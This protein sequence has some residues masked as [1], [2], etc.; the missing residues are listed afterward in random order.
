MTR[1]TRPPL[2]DEQLAARTNPEGEYPSEADDVPEDFEYGYPDEDEEPPP[3]PV[4]QVGVPPRDLPII[5]WS[6][7]NM[8]IGDDS[9][10]VLGEARHRMSAS[11]VNHSETVDVF[12][13]PDYNVEANGTFGK[14]A[15]GASIDFTHNSSVWARVASGSTA[16][17]SVY[18]EYLID[19][20]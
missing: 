16:E 5:R 14:V 2:T 7:D 18:T 15:A 6:S 9:I 17:I 11:I 3:L 8:T 4:Y 12:I 20:D 10:R 13:S 1:P 19:E